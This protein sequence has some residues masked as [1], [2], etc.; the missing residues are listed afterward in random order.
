[1]ATATK[2][3]KT[4]TAKVKAAKKAA[5]AKKDNDTHPAAKKSKAK[6][7]TQTVAKAKPLPKPVTGAGKQAAA[8]YKKVQTEKKPRWDL[9]EQYLPLVKSIVSRM[10]IYF[11]SH[12]DVEDIYS[13]GVTGLISASKNFDPER[14]HSFGNYASLRVRGSLLDELRRIDWMPRVERINTKKYKR[15]VEEL[16]QR[17]NRQAT[18]EEICTE[19]NLT[20]IEHERM[21]EQR[22]SIYMIPLDSSPNPDDPEAPTLHDAISDAT[23]MNGRD[24][25]EDNETL[26]ILRARMKE[27]PDVPRKVLTMYYL[28]GMRLAEIAEVFGLTES[29]IC[30]IHSQAIA[31]LRE[32]LLRAIKR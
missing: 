12:I 4:K 14:G 15:A 28:K 8:A 20:K 24:V 3:D 31:G 13:V 9:V 32:Y 27:L 22:K 6:T 21:K 1:M 11:P 10:R 17:L 18:D 5:S 25:A 26:K 2:F 19:L 30:Q 29:R 16:E 23:Q 7:T